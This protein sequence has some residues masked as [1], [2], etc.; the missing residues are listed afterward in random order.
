MG[1]F[2]SRARGDNLARQRYRRGHR[3]CRRPKFSLLDLVGVAHMIEDRFGLPASV[4]MRRSLDADFW[5]SAS[6]KD[7]GI[8]MLVT[9]DI[10][11]RLTDMKRSIVEIRSLLPGSHA[12]SRPR[13]GDPRGI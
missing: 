13:A 5:W 6:T 12:R 11:L 1:L 4:L 10:E 2:G 8:L 3:G 7:R 9:P